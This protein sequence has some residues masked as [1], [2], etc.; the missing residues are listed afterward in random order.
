MVYPS[1]LFCA[2][3]GFFVAKHIKLSSDQSTKNK[4]KSLPVHQMEKIP[5][6][7]GMMICK[8]PEAPNEHFHLD[9]VSLLS[10][11]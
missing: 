3:L 6:S 10:S 9:R 8:W 5:H 11:K 2:Y 7:S 1:L 4:M